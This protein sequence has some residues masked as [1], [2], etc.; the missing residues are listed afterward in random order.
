MMQS[1]SNK[2]GIYKL[3]NIDLPFKIINGNPSY[4]N[5][6]DAINS[7][8]LVSELKELLGK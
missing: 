2:S 3:N 8:L 7:W 5:L 1:I 4:I 6:L